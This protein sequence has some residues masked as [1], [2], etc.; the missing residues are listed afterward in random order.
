MEQVKECNI[1]YHAIDTATTARRSKSG[2]IHP[3]LMRFYPHSSS[4]HPDSLIANY[5]QKM[6]EELIGL[7]DNFQVVGKEV[8]NDVILKIFVYFKN[9]NIIT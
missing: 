6:K 1:K 5:E 3:F 9:I 8:V 7:C 4:F 2:L